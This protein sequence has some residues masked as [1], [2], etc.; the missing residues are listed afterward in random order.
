[1]KSTI[2]T[3]LSYLPGLLTALVIA[4]VAKWLES[5]L[6]IHII[7]ASVIAMFIGIVINAIKKPTATFA[8]GVK[9]TSKKI[10][11]FLLSFLS[12]VLS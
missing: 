7:G 1:M 4:A 2:K 5:L 9:F 12:S 10:L 6:P 8:P 11:N 3:Y